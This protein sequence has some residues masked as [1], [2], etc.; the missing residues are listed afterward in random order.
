MLRE[1]SPQVFQ[2][3]SLRIKSHPVGY[4]DSLELTR[5]TAYEIGRSHDGEEEDFCLSYDFYCY[6]EKP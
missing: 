6:K 2:S 1:D 5:L 4:I 3:W